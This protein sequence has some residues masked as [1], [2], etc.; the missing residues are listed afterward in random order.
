[1]RSIAIMSQKGGAG[2][3]TACVHL[4]VAAQLAGHRVAIIDTDPQRSAAAWAETR[5]EHDPTVVAIDA[6]QLVEALAEAQSDGYD[7]VFVDSE[8]RAAPIAAATA[9]AVDFAVV[10]VRPSAFDLATADQTQ[11]IVIAARKPGAIML[12]A[13]PTRAPEVAEAREILGRLDLPLLEVELTDRRAYG[14]AVQT[15]RSVQEFDP[16]GAAAL[17][18][19]RAWA[20]I[21]RRLS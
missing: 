17:E 11:R 15:G 21:E 14:R 16:K 9:R 6:S 13:C 3:T 5:G 10:P 4:A 1:M 19:A 12:N 8:P 20:A 7:I 18:I 2:K